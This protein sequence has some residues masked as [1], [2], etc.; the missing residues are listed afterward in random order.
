MCKAEPVLDLDVAS[1]TQGY[2]RMQGDYKRPASLH[3]AAPQSFKFRKITK[4]ILSS[5]I[6]STYNHTSSDCT[7]YSLHHHHHYYQKLLLDCRTKAFPNALH[8]V[9]ITASNPAAVKDLI[10]CLYI[11]RFSLHRAFSC[12]SWVATLLVWLFV[13]CPFYASYYLLISTFYLIVFRVS[14]TFVCS[15]IHDIRFL[16]L[17]VMTSIFLS[18]RLSLGLL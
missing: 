11:C 5:G 16:S 6:L 2:T 9:N 1:P 14:S 18:I 7:L 12:K 17:R 4:F 10:S 3:M 8:H 13:C 15:P